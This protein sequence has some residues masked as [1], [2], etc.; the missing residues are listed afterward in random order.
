VDA[1]AGDDVV[2]V[3]CA[4]PDGTRVTL[5]GSG[6]APPDA[7]FLWSAP[8][9]RFNDP[10]SVTPTGLFPL[11]LTT[12]Q[13]TVSL[14]TGESDTDSVDVEIVDDTPPTITAKPVPSVLWPPDH[15][16]RDV[17][18]RVLVSDNCSRSEDVSVTL[19]SA[20][21]SEPDDGNGD[22]NTSDDIQEADPGI[23]DRDVRLRAERA[24]GGDGRVYTLRY[25]AEDASGNQSDGVAR[26]RVPHDQAC[27]DDDRHGDKHGKKHGD[28]EDDDED[29]DEGNCDDDHGRPHPRPEPPDVDVCPLPMQAVERWTEVLPVSDEFDTEQACLSACRG[30]TTGCFQISFGSLHCARSERMGRF[31]LKLMRCLGIPEAEPRQECLLRAREVLTEM[32]DV[33]AEARA[34]GARCRELSGECRADCESAF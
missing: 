5:D 2:G 30:W 1:D 31:F 24:G 18:V 22:G 11:G 9:V 13:L 25:R 4:G 15:K 23:D 21:S 33:T 20:T 34:A 16:L 12:V 7:S 29:D 6:S 14:E 28:D 17:H 3:R 10:A 26:V 8:G 32:R 19:V 27:D